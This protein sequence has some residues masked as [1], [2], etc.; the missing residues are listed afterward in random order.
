MRIVDL[1]EFLNSIIAD[2]N[3]QIKI[4]DQEITHLNEQNYMLNIEVSKIGKRKRN[5]DDSLDGNISSNSIVVIK[6]GMGSLEI[7]KLNTMSSITSSEFRDGL[8]ENRIYTANQNDSSIIEHIDIN[9]N[10]NNLNDL[11]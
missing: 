4:L 8:N 6:K 9:I 11:A 2:K 7:K 3:L 1:I 10:E 5:L